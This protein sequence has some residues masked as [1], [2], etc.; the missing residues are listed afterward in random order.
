M[1]QYHWYPPLWARRQHARLSRSGPGFNPRLGQVSWVRFFWGFSSPVR[2]MSGSFRPP[3][4][5]NIIWPSLSSSL[6]IHYGVNDLR[7]WCALKPATCYRVCVGLFTY[8]LPFPFWRPLGI[9]SLWTIL[10]HILWFTPFRV[11]LLWAAYILLHISETLSHKRSVFEH[12]FISKIWS[13]GSHL[14][15]TKPLT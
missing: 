11:C 13:H 12:K 3:K 9:N 1:K 15:T 14:P 10:I 6:I 7:C 8:S 2:Q 4:S 5:Q